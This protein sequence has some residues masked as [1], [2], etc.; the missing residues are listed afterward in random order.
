MT[1][2]RESETFQNYRQTYRKNQIANTVMT[3]PQG[4][5]VW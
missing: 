1:T 2:G 3:V 5:V 4:V